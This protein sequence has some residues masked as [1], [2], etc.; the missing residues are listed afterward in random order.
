M[1][2]A[3]F[4]HNAHNRSIKG[5]AKKSSSADLKTRFLELQ[6]LRELVRVAECG[7][8]SAPADGT[9]LER[10]RILREQGPS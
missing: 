7:R 9:C 4:S 6:R 3:P 5:R 10:S 8:I 2:A 1:K